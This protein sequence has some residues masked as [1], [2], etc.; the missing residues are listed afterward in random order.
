VIVQLDE[1]VPVRLSKALA[2]VGCRVLKFPNKWKG[3]K[4]GELLARLRQN[5]SSCL[6][7]CD[8]NLQFQQAIAKSGLAI[9]VLPRQRFGDLMPL[10]RAIA[11]AIRAATPGD[12][13][14]IASDGRFST[15]P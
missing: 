1:S 7:T 10:V 4:N 2:S 14:T 8:K 6:V 5:G 9:A 15:E 11:A 13:L 12:V 3:L